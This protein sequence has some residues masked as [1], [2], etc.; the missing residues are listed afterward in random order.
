MSCEIPRERAHAWLDGELS[1]EATLD[2]ERHAREC[3]VCA[4]EYRR[5]L[6]LRAALREG[7]LVAAP[8]ASLEMRVRARLSSERRPSWRGGVPRWVA[9]AAG[10]LLGAG[11]TALMLPLRESIRARSLAD[12]LVTAHVRALMKGPLVEVPSSDR[13]TVKPWFAGRVDFAPKVKDLATR[14]FPLEGGRVDGVSDRRA[15]VLAY[16]HGPHEID[17]FV[18]VVAAP[19]PAVTLSVARGYHVARWTEGD[20]GYAAVSDMDEDELL[21]FADLVRN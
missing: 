15:A 21:A 12:A 1:A 7:G 2:A 20:L 3:P 8:P 10:L 18:W 14:G 13:H 5:G 9:V 6:A 19:S 16:R 11:L 17:V 4:A